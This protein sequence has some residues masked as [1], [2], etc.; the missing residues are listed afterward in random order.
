M[1]DTPAAVVLGE[2]P[3][4]GRGSAEVLVCASGNAQVG[5]APAEVSVYATLAHAERDPRDLGEKIGAASG[6]LPKLGNRVGFAHLSVGRKVPGGS[7]QPSAEDAVL[8][9]H[10]FRVGRLVDSAA[11]RL[12][13]A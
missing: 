8:V 2:G 7:R 10:C 4:R 13:V 12:R 5:D 6:K 11:L 3:A 1:L 9:A